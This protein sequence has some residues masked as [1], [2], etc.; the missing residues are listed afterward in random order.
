M[1]LL[2]T[3][4]GIANRSI[5]AALRELTGKPSQESKVGFV[6]IAANAEGRNKDWLIN[7][8]LNLWRHGYN[9][10]DIIDPTAADVQWEDRLKEVDIVFLSGGNTFHLLNQVRKTG[11]DKWLNKNLK[12]K[13]YVGGSA[14]TILATPTIEVASTPPGDPNLPGLNDLTGLGWV[15]FEIE[16]HCDQDR[17]AVVEKYAKSKPYPVYGIDDETAIKVDGDRVEVI[18]EGSWKLYD[19]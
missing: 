3:S 15:N 17:F 13:V 8:F 14:S 7:Q 4:S 1:K 6:P 10:I 11:F 19:A 5:A 12:N 9:W 18:S 16:P 2:L